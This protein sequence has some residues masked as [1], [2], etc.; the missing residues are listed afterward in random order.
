MDKKERKVQHEQAVRA[1]EL[2]LFNAIINT[3]AGVAKS[4]PDFV[5]MTFP[6]IL[7]F[8]KY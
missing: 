7:R 3:A 1:K 8:H 2:A 5:K 4:F 6:H